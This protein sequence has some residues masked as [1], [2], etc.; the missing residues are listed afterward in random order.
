MPRPAVAVRSG[1]VLAVVLGAAAC[2]QWQRVGTAPA[3]PTPAQTLTDIL[4]QTAVF[5]R[6]GRLTSAAGIPFVGVF[7]VVPGPA[8]TG[9]GILAVS[10]ENRSFSFERSPSGFEARYRA[11]IVLTRPGA[12]PIVIG[13]DQTVRVATFQETLRNDESVLFQE[14]IRLAPGGYHLALTITDRRSNAQGRAEADVVIPPG[15]PGAVSAPLFVYEVTPRTDPTQ[16]LKVIVN[17]R[18][19]VAY[20][21][22]TLGVYVEGYR[23][24][25]GA[26]VPV[27]VIDSRDTVL[28]RD[29]LV[30]TGATPVEGRLLKITPDSAP[31]GE[32]RVQVGDSA[33]HQQASALVSLSSSWIVTNYDQMADLLRYFGHDDELKAIKKAAPADRPGLWRKFWKDTD[34][35]PATP[36]NEAIDAYFTRLAAANRRFTD[37]GIAGWL[38]DRGSVYI[39]LGEPDQVYDASAYNQGRIIRWDYTQLQLTLYFVDETGFGRFRLTIASRADFDRVVDRL[40]RMGK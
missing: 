29:T 20:G 25:A 27:T 5:H 36:E 1:A 11:D 21:A 7:D 10:L 28:R 33:H 14:P 34:P 17:P 8:D 39:S 19:A 37:E 3:G 15:G 22:D 16:P 12:P 24:P 32:L 30:F 26:R 35:N 4:D 31:L 9:I 6:L 23:M 13:R 38:T 40:R 18:G 2:G